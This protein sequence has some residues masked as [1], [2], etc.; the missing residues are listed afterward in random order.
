MASDVTRAKQLLTIAIVSTLR[1]G[2]IT[3]LGAAGPGD[4]TVESATDAQGENS[5]NDTTQGTETNGSGGHGERAQATSE[6][7]PDHV[8]EIHETVDSLDGSLNE[9]LSDGEAADP[10]TGTDGDAVVNSGEDVS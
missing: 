8:S 9:L 2:G 7:V 1:F 5:P 4:Q 10:P 6:R 3:A